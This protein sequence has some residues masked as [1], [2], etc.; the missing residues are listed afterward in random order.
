MTDD[1]ILQ[2]IAADPAGGIAIVLELYGARL[3]GRFFARAREK[4][5][6]NAHVEDVLQET[7]VRLLDPQERASLR[8]AGGSILP[9]LTKWGYWR[10][11]DR[12]AAHNLSYDDVAPAVERASIEHQRRLEDVAAPS[13]ATVALQ[14]AWPRLAPRD[15]LLLLW[16]YGESRSEADIAAEHG[17]SLSAAKKG[18]HDARKRLRQLMKA[19]GF[20]IEE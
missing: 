5:Y 16:R 9:W 18:L 14:R 12:A 7:V 1:E 17:W 10:L 4:E 11:A 20:D 8:A 6:G 2:R 19:E 13:P 3:H 15:K